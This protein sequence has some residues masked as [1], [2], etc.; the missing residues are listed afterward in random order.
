MYLRLASIIIVPSVI[1]YRTRNR[2]IKSCPLSVNVFITIYILCARI[3]WIF[4][5]GYENKSYYYYYYYN[6]YYIQRRRFHLIYEIYLC[7]YSRA[8]L[9]SRS[10]PENLIRQTI[11][12]MYCFPAAERE[13]S[14]KCITRALDNAAVL[15]TRSKCYYISLYASYYM[16][17]YITRSGT[18][19]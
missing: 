8:K 6:C 19:P 4:R 5:S 12:N 11:G 16:I 9:R 7:G 2:R 15:G 18:F 1:Y 10:F 3:W 13:I 14:S 17:V